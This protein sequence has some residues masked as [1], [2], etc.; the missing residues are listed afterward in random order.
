MKI[1]CDFLHVSLFFPRTDFQKLEREARICR[2][3]QHPNI[4]E[5]LSFLLHA[6][7]RWRRPSLRPPPP[8]P[9]I[10]TVATPPPQLKV[11]FLRAKR[12]RVRV[13]R[14]RRGPPPSSPSL[15][16][17]RPAA[18]AA[19]EPCG[20]VAVNEEEASGLQRRIVGEAVA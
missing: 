19:L 13:S 11:T 3:L 2:K 6:L 14:G 18:S 16:L 12:R 1:G 15:E 17:P 7:V 5:F 8:P 9:P 10:L 4:G 20:S